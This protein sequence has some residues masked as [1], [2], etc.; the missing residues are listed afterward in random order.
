[1]RL[2]QP[3]GIEQQHRYRRIDIADELEQRRQLRAE[4]GDDRETLPADHFA[5][6]TY[7]L[8]RLGTGEQAVER[9]RVRQAG[10]FG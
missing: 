9:S 4:R 6:D 2:K 3:A 10:L 8:H 7:D 5:S 1:M